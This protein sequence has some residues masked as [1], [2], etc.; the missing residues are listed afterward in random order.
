MRIQQSKA[1]Q[2]LQRMCTHSRVPAFSL[3]NR[4]I[5]QALGRA[6]PT[7]HLPAVTGATLLVALQIHIS[8][9]KWWSSSHPSKQI[10]LHSPRCTACLHGWIF[11][12]SIS[13][14]FKTLK[15]CCSQ[16]LS[17]AKLETPSDHG[18]FM[19]YE[20]SPLKVHVQVKELS[21]VNS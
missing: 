18:A 16:I 10:N 2:G 5:K 4:I 6:C 17:S 14:S 20:C 3:W 9:C 12:C 8:H 1:L 7:S 21:Q 15:G 11:M 13:I 19:A